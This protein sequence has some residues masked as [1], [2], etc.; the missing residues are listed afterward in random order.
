MRAQPIEIQGKS[1]LI[2]DYEV[3]QEADQP[4]HENAAMYAENG[5]FRQE[6]LCFSMGNCVR[7][8]SARHRLVLLL[9]FALR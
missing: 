9:A 2:E 3:S 4:P 6:A 1:S 5:L 7:S 8:V